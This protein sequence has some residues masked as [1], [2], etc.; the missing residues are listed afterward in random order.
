MVLAVPASFLHAET[1]IN[2]DIT[3]ST[4]WDTAG[5]PYIIQ[6]NIEVEGNPP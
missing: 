6:A 2:S 4:T 5:S 1:I 3:T